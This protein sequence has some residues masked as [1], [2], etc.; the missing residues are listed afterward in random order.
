[1]ASSQRMDMRERHLAREYPQHS[2]ASYILPS[3]IESHLAILRVKHSYRT[4]KVKEGFGNQN[5]LCRNRELNP[6]S[7]GQKSDILPL[8]HQV[9]L[10]FLN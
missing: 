9:T 7:S 8:S 3:L 4:R 1:M 5:Y 2:N 10:I 6:G